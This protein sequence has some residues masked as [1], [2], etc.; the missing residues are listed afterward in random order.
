MTSDGRG[1]ARARIVMTDQNGVEHMALTNGFGYYR[2]KD[3]QSGETY[4][5]SVSAKNRTFTNPVIAR[6]VNDEVINMDFTANP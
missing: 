3:V 2:F 4:V 5:F 1:I 6:A